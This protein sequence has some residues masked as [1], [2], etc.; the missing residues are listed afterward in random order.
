MDHSFY[1]PVCD[2]MHLVWPYN[3]QIV[4]LSFPPS[5][6]V[7]P[8][9]SQAGLKSSSRSRS[10]DLL[11]HGSSPYRPPPRG[12]TLP[13]T[14]P[15]LVSF[16][17]FSP[18]TRFF[19]FHCLWYKILQ[20]LKFIANSV[21]LQMS[22]SQSQMKVQEQQSDQEHCPVRTRA[23][24]TG[25]D[26]GGLVAPPHSTCWTPARTSCTGPFIYWAFKI[27]LILFL[28]K[29]LQIDS[30]L[31]CMFLWY[32]GYFVQAFWVFFK[33]IILFTWF[34][35]FCSFQLL[36]SCLFAYFFFVALCCSVIHCV[37]LNKKNQ[38]TLNMWLYLHWFCCARWSPEL[39]EIL[40]M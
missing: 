29:I 25:I 3:T 15:L 13:P 14:L 38:I 21:F 36:P 23:T 20:N 2:L 6:R 30:F 8:D 33:N 17:P 9:L 39:N 11:S 4:T 10:L 1:F 22:P 26:E 19:P 32:I 18:G 34:F 40:I 37:I 24:D 35:F 12:E 16:T 5:P 28:I 7:L 31:L 27:E